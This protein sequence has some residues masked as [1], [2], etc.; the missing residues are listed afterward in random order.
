M[1]LE[2]GSTT[3][4]APQLRFRRVKSRAVACHARQ[5]ASR[6]ASRRPSV[7]PTDKA[8]AVST[9]S[10]SARLTRAARQ[11]RVGGDPEA[12][13]SIVRSSALSREELC[14]AGFN[15]QDFGRSIW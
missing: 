6:R 3:F 8:L 12:S 11:S 15:P 7:L 13:S 5:E 14:G 9:K 2:T 4:H 1:V 10:S